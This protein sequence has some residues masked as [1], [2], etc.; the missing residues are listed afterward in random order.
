MGVLWFCLVFL[1]H[2]TGCGGFVR[3]RADVGIGP[4]IHVGVRAIHRA[5]VGL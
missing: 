1:A 4:Y 3:L 2:S 5:G